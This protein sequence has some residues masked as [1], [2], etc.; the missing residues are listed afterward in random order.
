M[1][2]LLLLL[3]LLL[4]CILRLLQARA[5]SRS[6]TSVLMLLT[7]LEARKNSIS[8]TTSPRCT[9]LGRVIALGVV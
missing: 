6:C 7:C 5:C 2:L 3:L 4:Y 1:L 9:Y 8:S